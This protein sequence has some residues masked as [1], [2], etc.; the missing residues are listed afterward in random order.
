[1]PTGRPEKDPDGAGQ[2]PRA[3]QRCDSVTGDDGHDTSCVRGLDTCHANEGGDTSASQV[4]NEQPGHDENP[5]TPL[6]HRPAPGDEA[7]GGAREGN[8]GKKYIQSYDVHDPL[9]LGLIPWCPRTADNDM[10]EHLDGLTVGS[11]CG[12]YI[13]PGRVELD[14]VPRALKGPCQ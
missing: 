12:G 3:Y 6:R 4:R 10:L 9:D 5:K 13:C 8:R 2:T 11:D 7:K 14:G 1:V